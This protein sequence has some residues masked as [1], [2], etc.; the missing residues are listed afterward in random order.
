LKTMS[1]TLNVAC[2]YLGISE[3]QV[4]TW[5]EDETQIVMVVDLGIKGC[6]KYTIEKTTLAGLTPQPA[7]PAQGVWTDFHTADVQIDTRDGIDA[8]EAS[9]AGRV[10]RKIRRTKK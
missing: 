5:R 9:A 3:A 8:V 7:A 4:M 1:D 10:M 6:P 2:Q